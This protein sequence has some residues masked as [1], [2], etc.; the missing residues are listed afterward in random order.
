MAEVASVEATTG[1]PVHPD[2][3]R[4]GDIVGRADRPGERVRVSGISV[5]VMMPTGRTDPDHALRYL[6]CVAYGDGIGYVISVFADETM[7]RYPPGTRVN[8]G[9]HGDL[10]DLA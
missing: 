3:L 8:P 6:V 1:Q 9:P 10:T 4:P 2:E 7:L 5:P